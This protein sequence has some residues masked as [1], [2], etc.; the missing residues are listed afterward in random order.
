MKW[1][2][3]FPSIPSGPTPDPMMVAFYSGATG[4]ECLIAGLFFLRF[5]RDSRDR[6]FLRFAFAFWMLGVSY[7]LLGLIAFATDWRMYV[8]LVRLAAFCLILLGIVEKNRH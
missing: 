7:V 5:W 6:L 1:S 8:F 3:L 4:L 2:Q